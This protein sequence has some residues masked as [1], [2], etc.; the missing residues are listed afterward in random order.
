MTVDLATRFPH[1][2][3]H[4]ARRIPEP[5]PPGP[6]GKARPVGPLRVR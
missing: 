6:G 3:Q 5:G 4:G 1:L 2:G